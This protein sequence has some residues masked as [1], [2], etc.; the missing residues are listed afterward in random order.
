VVARAF[1]GI[2]AKDAE[3]RYVPGRTLKWLE[4]KLKDYRK[5]A[6]RFCRE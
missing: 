2:V 1:E 4:V 6:R 3:S 5:E